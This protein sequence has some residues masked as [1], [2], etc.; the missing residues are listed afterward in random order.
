MS[1]RRLQLVIGIIDLLVLHKKTQRLL[2]LAWA[3]VQHAHHL[4]LSLITNSTRLIDCMAQVRGVLQPHQRMHLAKWIVE[5]AVC[6][7]YKMG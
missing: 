7:S 2:E 3:L 6:I 4:Y 5:N 1:I